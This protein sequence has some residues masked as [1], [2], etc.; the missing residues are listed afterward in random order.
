MNYYA[1]GKLMLFGEYLVLKGSQ[2]LAAPVKYGQKMEVQ[3]IPGNGIKWTSRVQ[4]REW[5]SARFDKSLSTPEVS[6]TSTADLLFKLLKL[7]QSEKPEI[8]HSGL[9]IEVDADF[10]LEWGFG[11]SSTL[12]SLL[13]QWSKLD[14]Y[15]LLKKTIGGS[16]FDLACARETAPILYRMNG[17]KVAHVELSKSITS[18]LLFVYSGKKQSSKNEIER[19]NKLE[20][21]KEDIYKMD[22]IVSSVTLSDQIDEFEKWVVE[23]ENLISGIIHSPVIKENK[24]KD[25]PFTLKSLGAWGGDFFMAT[26]RNEKEARNYFSNLGYSIQFNYSQ[27]IKN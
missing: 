27:L 20:I 5:F 10:P 16:G 4:G 25:Y 2:C 12:I 15:F 9:Q 14:P 1:S 6:N 3:S 13:A 24:F 11:S 23:S 19:F 21:Q 26:Y 22:Q 8:F 7:I 18:K 17:N